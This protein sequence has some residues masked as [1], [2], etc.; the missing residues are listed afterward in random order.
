MLKCEF[1]NGVLKLIPT[2]ID[3]YSVEYIYPPYDDR[4]KSRWW[5]DPVDWLAYPQC[6]SVCNNYGK[7][8]YELEC[9]Y[10]TN[11]LIQCTVKNNVEVPF[12]YKCTIKDI[13]PLLDGKCAKICCIY[14]STIKQIHD[15]YILSID[16]CT[17][18]KIGS[19]MIDTVSDSTI[20]K[21]N[22]PS[23]IRYVNKSTIKS[24]GFYVEIFNA[25]R[26]TIKNRGGVLL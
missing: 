6:I 23:K 3:N 25:Q 19:S 15:S 7:L 1:N 2:P 20:K 14:N 8:W 24:C 26:S 22:G 5:V 10:S 16:K 17:I 21:I 4:N 11:V 18:N 9:W 12:I 13:S